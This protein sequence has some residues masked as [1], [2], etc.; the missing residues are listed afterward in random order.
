MDVLFVMK[1]SINV[2]YN[3]ANMIN[4][5]NSKNIKI[6]EVEEGEEENIK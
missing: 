3:W 4:L 2:L 6:E 1:N 5:K